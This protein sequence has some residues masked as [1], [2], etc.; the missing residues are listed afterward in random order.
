V[1]IKFYRTQEPYGC[2]ANFS[3][4]GFELDGKY[5]KTSE[6]Y[7]QAQKFV[8]TPFEEQVRLVETPKEAAIIG[9]DRNLPLRKD[10]EQIKDDV[11]RKAVLKKI[12]IHEMIKL[13]L[14]ETGDEEIIED[15]P[16]DYYWGCGANG[17]GKNMLG[18]IL[19]EIRNELRQQTIN[20]KE[21]IL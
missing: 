13:V 17:S 19:M 6:H 7:F 5:W 20:K 15:S 1:T 21:G 3:R 14:L 8:G 12:E 11:M 16:V 4:H 2:F 9:R 18:K 10:W